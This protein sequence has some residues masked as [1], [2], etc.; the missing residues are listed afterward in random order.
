[1][2]VS[3]IEQ[4]LPQLTLALTEHS[5]VIL[6]AP[7]GCGKTTRVPLALLNE[8]WLQSQR[9]LMLEPR[10]LAARHAATYMAQQLGQ[11]VGQTVGYRFRGETRTGKDTRLEVV[12]DGILTRMIQQDPMLSDYGL[13]I[14]D[15]FHERHMQTDLGLALLRDAQQGLE[16]GV[17]ILLMSATLDDEMLNSHF[18]GAPQIKLAQSTSP[19]TI[20]YS[21][22][23]DLP[24]EQKLDEALRQAVTEGKGDIL[25][26]L[27]GGNE[28]K[29][30]IEAFSTKAFLKE[31]S[32]H[33]L[34]GELPFDVQRN[35]LMPAQGG[36]RKVIF[37]TNI[38]ESSLT[39]DGVDTVIDAGLEK[40]SRFYSR[41]DC[42][43]LTT[44][45]ISHFSADQRAGRAGRQG[46]GTCFRL[47]SK[48]T[49]HSL[50]KSIEPEIARSDLSRFCLELAL[51]GATADK[52]DWLEPP[53]GDALAYADHQLRILGAL[54]KKDRITKH[55][56]DMAALSLSPALADMVLRY[57]TSPAAYTACLVAT[58]LEERDWPGQ[59]HV[60]LH[61]RLGRLH[62]ALSSKP[63]RKT[64]KTTALILQQ[65][66]K[67]ARQLNIKATQ[68]DDA[69]VTEMLCSTFPLRIGK[70]RQQDGRFLLA[71]GKGAFMP[72]QDPLAHAEFVVVVRLLH[73]NPDA[74][75][76]L[77]MA[78]TRE[79]IENFCADRLEV[80]HIFRLDAAQRCLSAK[81]QTCLGQMVLH[82]NSTPERPDYA[83][84]WL[85]YIR[86]NGLKALGLSDKAS[87]LLRRVQFVHF[88][89][90][91]TGLPDFSEAG[92]TECLENWLTAD[93]LNVRC[94]DDV[95]RNELA[96]A[97][98]S[99]LDWPQRQ[100]LE[101][102]APEK[103]TSPCGTTI[104]I[105]YSQPEAPAVSVR[106]QEMYG[107]K[108]NPTIMN[109]QVALTLNL[110]SPA[111]RV[112]QVTRTLN[113]FWYDSYTELKK[114]MKGR[115]PKH[116]WP[117]D[118]LQAE[119]TR[120]TRRK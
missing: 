108:E 31:F 104:A 53:P 93:L 97:L 44:S 120:G 92:L 62:R 51:W 7:P 76:R 20:H 94:L 100:I 4:I 86:E 119:P 18:A 96:G 116:Y 82:E 80:R 1:M 49:D 22:R 13:V 26:F 32:L 9:I 61:E 64:D 35:A 107:C 19:V 81:K 56:R 95:D 67:L 5:L 73:Q 66:N 99:L 25:V 38:A 24:L 43:S 12:T 117:D 105:D 57:R 11:P 52:L 103:Y 65:T 110:L 98:L 63:A 59:T 54:D 23:D 30:T 101:R 87:A 40:V 85:E 89:R 28:I 34:Y 8:T 16:S 88:H 45:R 115:Y 27:P 29:R 74:R 14:F 72:E 41:A 112:I 102:L 90:D 2:A 33:P 10:R 60:D 106:I 46:P 118:P 50:E 55:G 6:N 37:A 15:E 91:D 42:F 39:I 69:N 109:E 114:E 17:R 77:A 113:S 3:S 58:L 48:H 21:K 79:E 78:V 84:F 111:K 68:S 75:I 83:T 47:W 71:N 70:R 36:G